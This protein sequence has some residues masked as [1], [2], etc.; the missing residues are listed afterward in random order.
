[1]LTK[2]DNPKVL[3]LQCAI[4]FQRIEGKFV[5]IESL[6]LQEKEYLRNV[7]SRIL[8][9]KPDVILIHKN[10]A[11]IAQDLLR[12][13][14]VTLVLDVKQAVLERLSRCLECDIITSID[15]NIGK[16]KLG[17]CTKFNT[18]QFTNADGL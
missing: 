7:T 2:I 5:T 17:N 15:S 16:P 13:N 8:S 18:K 6:L 12:D 10:V 14:G 11:G 9:L 1:M 3:L 4:A